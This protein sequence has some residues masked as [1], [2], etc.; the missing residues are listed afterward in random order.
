MLKKC[1]PQCCDSRANLYRYLAYISIS[2][3]HPRVCELCSI[4]TDSRW[5]KVVL[6]QTLTQIINTKR[7]APPNIAV[8]VDQDWFLID[9]MW[10][11][12]H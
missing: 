10:Q 8:L 1:L 5:Y 9:E 11:Q 12:S 3:W 6:R 7:I 2:H 4:V